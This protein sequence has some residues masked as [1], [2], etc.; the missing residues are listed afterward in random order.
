MLICPISGFK[1]KKA[2]AKGGSLWYCPHSRGR[3]VT[4][5]MSKHFFGDDGTREI[6]VRS[7]YVS[8]PSPYRC[9]S[10]TK[11]MRLVSEPRWL[12]NGEIDVCRTCH[13]IWI[14]PD[15]HPEVPHPEDFMAP[16][17]DSTLVKRA[18]DASVDLALK[19][20]ELDEDKKHLLGRGPDSLL[21][22]IPAFLGLPVEMSGRPPPTRIW[23]T[24]FVSLLAFFIYLFWVAANPQ[25]AM[26]YGFYPDHP[27]K[28]Y[29]LNIFAAIF[30]HGNWLHL[31]SNL[32]FFFIF[33]DDVEQELGSARYVLFLF[34]ATLLEG[35][36]T[37]LFAMSKD[38]PHVGMSGLVMAVLVFYALQFSKSRIAYVIPGVHTIF[39]GQGIYGRVNVLRWIRFPV[40]VVMLMYV[41]KDVLL[42]YF[43]ERSGVS[44]ISHSGHLAGAIA[45]LVLWV[46]FTKMLKK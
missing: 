24:A 10:C 5:T 27:F 23:V 26:E 43:V 12:G 28:N 22:S 8:R 41:L 17:G 11:P 14:K 32:Y 36:Y 35:I 31:L 6:W 16:M 21:A 46:F 39:L 42:Y 34:L 3:L 37:H 13:L 2:Y 20:N 19:Q 18:A 44:Q 29:G 25:V 15:D 4:L 30:I 33:S 40:W 9:P 45:G 1:L 7:E 38:I